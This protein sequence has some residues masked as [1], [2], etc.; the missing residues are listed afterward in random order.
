MEKVGLRGIILM[1]ENFGWVKFFG[2][3]ELVC[4]RKGAAESSMTVWWWKK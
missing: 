2:L 3:P 1:V 4:H